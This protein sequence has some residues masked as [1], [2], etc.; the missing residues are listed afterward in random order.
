MRWLATFLFIVALPVAATAQTLEKVALIDKSVAYVTVA[1]GLE[2]ITIADGAT[3]WRSEKLV[4]PLHVRGEVL[5]ATGKRN[6]ELAVTLVNRASGKVLAQF[7]L[8]EA[9]AHLLDMRP[10]L[11]EHKEVSSRIDADIL[12]VSW[13]YAY[14]QIRGMRSHAPAK[15][16]YASGSIAVDLKTR[17]VVEMQPPKTH[18]PPPMR[19]API[20]PAL[21][22]C[23]EG[24][25][26]IERAEGRVSLVRVTGKRR[27]DQRVQ[28]S[29]VDTGSMFD[30][31][32][33]RYVLANQEAA[34]EGPATPRRLYDVETM[35]RVGA[36]ASDVSYEGF[37]IRK[38]R[39]IGFGAAPNGA[40]IVVAHAFDGKLIWSR[41][42]A[43]YQYRGP[44]PQ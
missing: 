11:G 25:C 34:D 2:A 36:F 8:G 38:D 41:A 44:K 26:K 28:I 33:R 14:Q 10:A 29:T 43:E 1:H 13:V 19:Q 20:D 16:A 42:V 21:R 22:R 27:P 4:V 37:V 40:P 18:A 23:F 31:E 39:F 9:S 3:E 30:L 24:W 7:P 5:I 35:T 32:Q 15:S 12:Y 6:G 17:K